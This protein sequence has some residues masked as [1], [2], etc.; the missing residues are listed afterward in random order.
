MCRAERVPLNDSLKSFL[1]QTLPQPLCLLP[2]LDLSP[3]A[4]SP[5]SR[6]GFSLSGRMWLFLVGFLLHPTVVGAPVDPGLWPGSQGFLI[7]ERF[8]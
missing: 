7:N 5:S 1:L 3:G 4:K 8:C 2:T 6:S